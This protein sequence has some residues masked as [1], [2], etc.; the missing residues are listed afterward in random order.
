[1]S[2]WED[3][4]FAEENVRGVYNVAGAHYSNH[5]IFKMNTQSSNRFIDASLQ[6]YLIINL[7]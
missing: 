5:L 1:M 6:L 3:L 4:L 2:I 7:H